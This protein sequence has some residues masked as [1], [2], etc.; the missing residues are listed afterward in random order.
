MHSCGSKPT[1]GVF[2]AQCLSVPFLGR[3]HGILR[4]WERV[5]WEEDISR[6]SFPCWLVL[7]ALSCEM[8]RALS[9]GPG[10]ARPCWHRAPSGGEVLHQTNQS[11]S[12]LQPAR[13]SQPGMEGCCWGHWDSESSAGAGSTESRRRSSGGAR[14]LREQGLDWVGARVRED[15]CGLPLT[16]C[17]GGSVRDLVPLPAFPQVTI[18]LYESVRRSEGGGTASPVTHSRPSVSRRGGGG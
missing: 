1:P 15:S 13:A 18:L 17:H 7:Q 11:L 9:Q 5:A 2:E 16:P 3:A 8:V 12:A 14:A 6:P 4:A 10:Q